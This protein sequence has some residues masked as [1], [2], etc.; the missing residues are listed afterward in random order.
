[1]VSQGPDSI[2]R[3]IIVGAGSSSASFILEFCRLQPEDVRIAFID[4]SEVEIQNLRNS[5]R[6]VIPADAFK[7]VL[8]GKPEIAGGLVRYRYAAEELGFSYDRI[9]WDRQVPEDTPPVARILTHIQWEDIQEAI[10][11]HLKRNTDGTV[12]RE[13]RIIYVF[14]VTGMT[15]STVAVEVSELYKDRLL[16]WAN[17]RVN[18]EAR[19][20][21]RIGLALMSP[22]PGAGISAY[23]L[24]QGYKVCS[25]LSDKIPDDDASPDVRASFPFD[26]LFL[27]DGSGL[28][29]DAWLILGQDQSEFSRWSAE[30]L[31]TLL[32]FR[33]QQTEDTIIDVNEILNEV[34]GYRSLALVRTGWTKDEIIAV[35]DQMELEDFLEKPKHT[36]EEVS[37][38]LNQLRGVDE[39]IQGQLNAYRRALDE[40][41]EAKND[42]AKFNSSITRFFRT[43]SDIELR[44][45][46]A[47]EKAD[48]A[49]YDLNVIAEGRADALERQFRGRSLKF[50]WC[51]PSLAQTKNL[52]EG[53]K[54]GEVLENIGSLTGRELWAYREERTRTLMRMLDPAT[55]HQTKTKYIKSW[56]LGPPAAR[57][58]LPFPDRDL[59]YAMMDD[60]APVAT[61]LY[62]L[63]GDMIYSMVFWIPADG[64]MMP[65]YYRNQ[66]NPGQYKLPE[67]KDAW[68]DAAENP[69]A[70]ELKTE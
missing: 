36:P 26:N 24:E 50:M 23:N 29:G 21:R 34:R 62:D 15:S 52:V 41:R 61:A 40:E 3:T 18:V 59:Q 69:D 8:L 55:N 12:A 53:R 56:E 66:Q 20:I 30:T 2:Y 33:A 68:P 58:S 7:S 57:E 63:P 70:T 11:Y 65:R 35:Q 48:K 31:S 49:F 45:N 42:L 46:M 39:D 38:I 19:E 22:T 4:H 17:D 14:G 60:R 67:D 54:P 6:D 1:M 28:G 51:T 9:D 64:R 5:L 44:C 32:C 10:D 13:N 47:R 27:I 37:R 43:P 16:R 25:I